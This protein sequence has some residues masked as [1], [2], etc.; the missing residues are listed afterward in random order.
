MVSS[1]VFGG[2]WSKHGIGGP[3]DET[4]TTTTITTKLSYGIGFSRR[5]TKNVEII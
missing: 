3:S 2:K 1:G 5:V 4:A